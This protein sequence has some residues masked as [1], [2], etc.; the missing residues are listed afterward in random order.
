MRRL[1]VAV[2]LLTA[3]V[4]NTAAQAL[5]RPTSVLSAS[6]TAIQVRPSER[7][8]F[9]PRMRQFDGNQSLILQGLNSSMEALDLY[10]SSP[11]LNRA[12][13]FEAVRGGARNGETFLG[14]NQKIASELKEAVI[15]DPRLASARDLI[16]R[17]SADSSDVLIPIFD[18]LRAM[19][20]QIRDGGSVDR[21]AIDALKRNASVA[22]AQT[23]ED[24]KALRTAI[25]AL[26][27]P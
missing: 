26:A 16:V 5:L 7:D 2:A 24:Q 23:A 14:S 17:S 20:I 15:S 19:A 21:S 25:G 13:V 9:M 18:N 3:L 27:Q 11:S 12:M 22:S 4:A 10:R 6:A 8:R 1:P